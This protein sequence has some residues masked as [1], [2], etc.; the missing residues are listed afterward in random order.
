MLPAGHV[1]THSRRRH[2]DSTH[3]AENTKAAVV[4]YV[5][6]CNPAARNWTPWR[7]LLFFPSP[8]QVLQPRYLPPSPPLLTLPQS[9][10]SAGTS[11]TVRASS[12]SGSNPSRS[13]VSPVRSCRA[14]SRKTH[15]VERMTAFPNNYKDPQSAEAQSRR[16]ERGHT[17]RTI[18]PR[19]PAIRTRPV[20]LHTTDAAHI[21]LGNVPAP[22][23]DCV[24]ALDLD[25]HVFF[26]FWFWFFLSSNRG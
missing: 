14:H 23:S 5:C 11:D 1:A 19:K 4:L 2:P 13:A 26:C 8:A 18:V 16:K 15:H 21:V 22:R 3:C 9:Q 20:E 12:Q 17:Q 10:T 7:A 24:P 25:L 6:N